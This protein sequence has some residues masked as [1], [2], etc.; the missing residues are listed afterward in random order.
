MNESSGENDMVCM[1][2]T[3]DTNR[4][5]V[6]ISWGKNATNLTKQYILFSVLRST[7]YRK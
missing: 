6:R 1:I 2:F 5:G 3:S 7:L 4:S